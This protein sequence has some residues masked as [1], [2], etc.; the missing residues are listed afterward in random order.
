VTRYNLT[1]DQINDAVKQS[2]VASE[3]K[4]YWTNSGVDFASVVR[5]AWNN[6][7]GGEQQGGSTITQQYARLA[8]DLRGATYSRKVR[9]AIL[10][11]KLDQDLSKETILEYYLNAVPFGRNTYGIEAAAQAFFGKTANRNAPAAQ[12]LTKADAM[13]LVSMIKQPEPVRG[14]PSHPGYDP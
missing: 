9:E 4:T 11:W 3:D 5:A 1:Y 13:V 14:D 6:V 12:Q 7:T 2:V 10:A 8:F